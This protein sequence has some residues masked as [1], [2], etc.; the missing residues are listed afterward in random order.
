MYFYV[1]MVFK[2]SKKFLNFILIVL[3]FAVMSF[4]VCGRMLPHQCFKMI[5]KS[6]KPGSTF[7]ETKRKIIVRRNQ[8]FRPDLHTRMISCVVYQQKG[9]RKKSC[10][11][12]YQPWSTIIYYNLK[13]TCSKKNFNN[14]RVSLSTCP[15]KSCGSILISY[16]NFSTSL[17]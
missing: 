2:E 1:T 14:F 16:I 5:R 4:K 12:N 10:S 11:Q 13:L 15:S 3:F 9:F 17:N 7:L 6:N 8:L